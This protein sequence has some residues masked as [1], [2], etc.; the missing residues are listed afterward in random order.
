M[1]NHFIDRWTKKEA[2]PSLTSKIKNVGKPTVDL[3]EQIS[4]VINRLDAQT[5]SLD[6]AVKRFEIRDA[7][8][9]QRVVKAM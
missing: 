4:W 5:Q 1:V 8:I 2:E 6:R 7:D 9:F 3:K